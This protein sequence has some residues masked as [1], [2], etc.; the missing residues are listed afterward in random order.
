MEKR[1]CPSG[2]GT[3]QRGRH[4]TSPTETHNKAAVCRE[5]YTAFVAVPRNKANT[6]AKDVCCDVQSTNAN[7]TA[8]WL[9]TESA[10]QDG[11]DYLELQLQQ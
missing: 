9:S 4:Q 11:S 2:G 8:L 3:Q 1:A 10:Q 6:A 5:K 7:E